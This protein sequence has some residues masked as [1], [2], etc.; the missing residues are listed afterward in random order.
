M[1]LTAPLRAAYGASVPVKIV[2]KLPQT[3][4]LYVRR[5]HLL[6]DKIR[7]V[8]LALAVEFLSLRIAN[9]VYDLQIQAIAIRFVHDRQGRRKS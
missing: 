1:Q 9:N 6:V 8:R 4:A 5:M 7:F 3:A 2:S